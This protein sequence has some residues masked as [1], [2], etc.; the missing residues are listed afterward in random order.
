MRWYRRQKRI[1]SNKSDSEASFCAEPNKG[2]STNENHLLDMELLLNSKSSL[3][4][5]GDQGDNFVKDENVIEHGE[6]GNKSSGINTNKMVRCT[7][8][9]SLE[10]IQPFTITLS[11]NSMLL[12]DFHCHLTQGEVVGYLGGTWDITSHNLSIVQAFPCRSRLGDKD[13]GALIEEEIR[14]ALERRH[15]N[16]VG[17]YHR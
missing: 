5:S 15:L 16:V 8:F 3:F 4:I 13:N 2:E 6:V 11:T 9:S 10:R 12:I 1:S 7:P 14:Q 17:W